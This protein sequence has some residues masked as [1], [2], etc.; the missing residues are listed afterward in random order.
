[1]EKDSS[2]KSVYTDSNSLY[3]ILSVMVIKRG[4]E[5]NVFKFDPQTDLV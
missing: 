5:T 1:M 2:F 4:A 3:W